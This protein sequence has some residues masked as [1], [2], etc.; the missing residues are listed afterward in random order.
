MEYSDGRP[1]ILVVED[2]DWIRTAMLKG[3]QSE[4]YDALEAMNDVEALHVAERESID[5]ILTEEELPTFDSLMSRL[6]Q[7]PTLCKVPVVIIHP[8]ADNGARYRDAYLLTD[9]CDISSLLLD[10]ASATVS[11]EGRC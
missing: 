10:I 3:I 8:D 9:Y 4:G 7:H 5:L 11:S 1:K 2:I 6:S